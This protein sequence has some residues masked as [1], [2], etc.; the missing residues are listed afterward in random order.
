M[1]RWVKVKPPRRWK[2]T[3]LR[4]ALWTAAA[5]AAYC[6]AYAM[7]GDDPIGSFEAPSQRSSR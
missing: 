1:R 6:I 2:R 4:I 7:S 3:L 5:A